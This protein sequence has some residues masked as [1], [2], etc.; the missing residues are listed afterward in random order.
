MQRRFCW[1]FV[2]GL[3]GLLVA[4]GGAGSDRTQTVQEKSPKTA[5]TT[6]LV[7]SDPPTL[8]RLPNEALTL[9]RFTTNRP[10]TA[11]YDLGDH[12]SHQTVDVTQTHYQPLPLLQPTDALQDAL[13]ITVTDRSGNRVE[14]AVQ[15]P[16]ALAALHRELRPPRLNWRKDGRRPAYSMLSFARYDPATT[17]RAGAAALDPGYGLLQVFDR[18]GSAIWSYQHDAMIEQVVRTGPDSLT[19]LTANGLAVVDLLGT[20]LGWVGGRGQQ[21]PRLAADKGVVVGSQLGSVER[22]RSKVLPLSDGNVLVMADVD[23]RAPVVA[24]I[25]PTGKV[26]A[27]WDL[28]SLLAGQ[29]GANEPSPQRLTPSDIAYDPATQTIVLTLPDQRV[30]LGLH[31]DKPNIQWLY[32]ARDDLSPQLQS[33]LLRPAQETAADDLTPQSARSMGFAANG[34]LVLLASSAPTLSPLEGQ[35][36]QQSRDAKN[37]E[38]V[39]LRIDPATHSYRVIRYPLDDDTAG[40]PSRIAKQHGVQG[41]A[42]DVF[43]LLNS[44]GQ[45]LTNVDLETPQPATT[46]LVT[47]DATTEIARSSWAITDAVALD[48]WFGSSDYAVAAR[49]AGLDSQSQDVGGTT[50]Q[51]KTAL[52]HDLRFEPDLTVAGIDISG[53]W[54]IT[55]GDAGLAPTQ[56]LTLRQDQVVVTG[57]LGDQAITGVI[58]GNTFSTTYRSGRG[59]GQVK[60]KYRGLVDPNESYMEGRVGVYQN[61]QRLDVTTWQ[62]RKR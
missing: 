11:Q 38:L 3:L 40:A 1:P 61:A 36:I 35:S 51:S 41:T 28:S 48:H 12:W 7:F 52:F 55:V 47:V 50:A 32:T 10:V 22:L 46:T 2:W 26:I 9:I 60:F 33:K 6:T 27:R 5:Q 29:L 30:L 37:A 25:N 54:E 20:P 44:D 42:P 16:S 4:C 62:A 59:D 57:E 18:N 39:R 15:V 8:E 13:R 49:R 43:W 58:R 45:A 21:M 31:R 17:E 24:E 56:L 23:T 19:L 34:D 14:Q 53:D